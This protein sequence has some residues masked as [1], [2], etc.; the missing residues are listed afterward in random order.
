[1]IDLHTHSLL[2]DGQ[3]LPSE[4]ARR[5]EEKGFKAIAITD[6]ADLSNLK[7][8]AESIVEFC[9]HWPKGRIAVLPGVELTHLPLEQFEQAVRFSRQKGLR[10]IVGHGE[11][12]AEPVVKGT[13]RAAIKAGVDILAHPGLISEADVKLAVK[14]GVFLELSARKG[15]C[16]GNGHVARL[17]L[18]YD[19]K[20]CINSDAHA[21]SDIPGMAYFKSIG[22]GAGLSLKDL[23]KAYK[24]AVRLVKC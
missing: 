8:V 7:F 17:A 9:R 5:Y 16:L 1:M 13:N 12:L 15:H 2:S 19:A 6:H 20:L 18:K 14:R 10:I 22:L 11:T 21:P 24:E 23:V 4:L 3:L